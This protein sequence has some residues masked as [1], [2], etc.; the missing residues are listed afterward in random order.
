MFHTGLS[1]D[2]VSWAGKPYTEIRSV[3]KTDGSVLVVPVG[4]IEQH[5]PHMPVATDIILADAVARGGASVAAED[6]VPVLV[7]PPVWTGS[8]DHH[9]H[10]GGTITID[11]AT[12]LSV[13]TQIA[14]SA[15]QNSFDAI[16]FLNGHGGNSAIVNAATKTVGTEHPQVEVLATTYYFLAEPIAGEIRESRYGGMSHAGEFE[17]SLI[18]HLAPDLVCEDEY[19][20]DY[21]E[22]PKGGYEDAFHDFF[23]HGPLSVYRAADAQTGPGT[24]GDPTLASADKGEAIYEFLIEEIGALL[25]EIAANNA[26]KQST[27]DETHGDG[28]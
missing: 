26:A 25:E 6:G 16:F 5:G 28:D 13:L 7:T 9:L 10:W 27:P 24:T 15:L 22:E 14:R 2:D 1:V 11:V 19:A 12:M 8:S 3:G 21:R 23:S 4:S 17:T 18:L 20:V